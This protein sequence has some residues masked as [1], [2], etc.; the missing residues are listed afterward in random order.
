[1]IQLWVNLPAKYKMSPPRYQEITSASIPRI[2][3]PNH[4][5][6]AR[7]IAGQFGECRGPAATFTPINLWEL[8]LSAGA[9][10]DLELPEGYHTVLVILHGE[11]L[12][13][14]AET[15]TA[16]EIAICSPD[17]ESIS[18]QA[19]KNSTVLVL[20]GEPIDEPVA[21]YGPF[22][23]NTDAEIKQAIKDFNDGKFLD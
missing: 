7:I 2:E 21:G 4:A 12:I 3:L 1:M 20:N 10:I 17:G 14:H 5:G 19:R 11:A 8:N 9:E 6:T 16:K 18:L 22:V 13:H 23:M 15:L